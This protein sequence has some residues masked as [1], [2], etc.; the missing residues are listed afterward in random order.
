VSGANAAFSGIER[1]NFRLRPAG[2]AIAKNAKL[3]V[4]TLFTVPAIW[5]LTFYLQTHINKF[6]AVSAMG[7]PF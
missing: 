2:F 1:K 6:A 3:N 7:S 5:R 4:Y